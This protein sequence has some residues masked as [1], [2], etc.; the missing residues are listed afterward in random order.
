[1]RSRPTLARILRRWSGLQPRDSTRLPPPRRAAARWEGRRARRAARR[2]LR[3]PVAQLAGL[4]RSKTA[5]W[6]PCASSRRSLRAASSSERHRSSRSLA[7]G[8][9][10]GRG[11]TEACDRVGS[12]REP[13]SPPRSKREHSGPSLR[14]PLATELDDTEQRRNRGHLTQRRCSF[15]SELLEAASTRAPLR[16]VGQGRAVLRCRRREGAA[17]PI[18][19]TT[20]TPAAIP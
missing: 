15:E 13:G 6:S 8:S 12:T 5:G 9:D 18:G 3:D 10:A 2:G 7:A 1:V 11:T 19:L 14:P 16:T 20:S 17:P 4:A